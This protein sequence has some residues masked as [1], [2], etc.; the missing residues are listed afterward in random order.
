[1]SNGPGNEEPSPLEA[2]SDRLDAARGARKTLKDA[3]KE[4]THAL[5]RAIRM[6]TEILAALLVGIGLG[7]GLDYLTGAKPWFLLLGMALGFAAGVL[8]VVRTLREFDNVGSNDADA[9][10]KPSETDGAEE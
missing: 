10:I 6:G 4:A 8:N 2:F 3:P 1:M 7:V 9:G 5:G